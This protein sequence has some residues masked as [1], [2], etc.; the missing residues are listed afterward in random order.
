[1]SDAVVPDGPLPVGSIGARA[2]GWWGMLFFALSEASIFA[3]LCFAYFYFNVQPQYT[4]WPPYGAPSFLYAIP[5]TVLVL[6]GAAAMW[7]SGRT[8]ATARSLPALGAI[9]AAVVCGLAFIGLGL[10]DWASKPFTLASSPYASLYLVTTGIHLAH[11][12][13]GVVIAVAVLVWTALGYFRPVRHAPVNV[14]ALYW[15]FL[16]GTWI[17]VF[18]TLYITPHL[19]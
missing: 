14:A 7:W 4:P 5:Q 11:V 8:A 10:A 15:G 3:Y 19:G 6:A 2:S 12:L 18:F 16:A 1:M 17:A 9:A 13:V